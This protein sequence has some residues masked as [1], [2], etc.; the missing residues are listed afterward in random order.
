M[1]AD[2][3]AMAKRTGQVEFLSTLQSRLLI[4]TNAPDAEAL[5][6][7]AQEAAVAGASTPDRCGRTP[8]RRDAPLTMALV[9]LGRRDDAERQPAIHLRHGADWTPHVDP[10][11]LLFRSALATASGQ[12]AEGKALAAEAAL[13][14]GRHRMTVE[15][16]YTSQINNGRM[17]Q[18]RLDAAGRWLS[19]LDSLDFE[20]SSGHAGWRLCR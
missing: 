4:E 11:A 13:W 3:V 12:F 1:A 19:A 17:E 16:V 6:R 18:G 5:P 20:A 9:R 7:T 8:Q 2:A 15:L 10:G 14:A